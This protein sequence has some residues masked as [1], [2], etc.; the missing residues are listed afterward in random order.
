M[1]KLPVIFRV[2]Q[3]HGKDKEIFAL[4]PTI[5]G[6]TT[7]LYCQSYQQIGQHSGADYTGCIR[8]SRPATPEEYK[9]LLA[10]L[11]RIGYDNLQVYKRSSPKMR[12]ALLD[13]IN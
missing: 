1:T 12:K 5:A 10:E 11:V 6:D 13:D 3:E 9:E 8:Q 4:F 7:G 2:W